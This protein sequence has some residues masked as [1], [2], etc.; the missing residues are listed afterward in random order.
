MLEAD[1]FFIFGVFYSAFVC[2]SAIGV[3]WWLET[4]D[5]WGL[6]WLGDVFII[7]WIGVS[8]TA[9]AWMKV[10]MVRVPHIHLFSVTLDKRLGQPTIQYRMQYDGHHH[11][12]CPRQGGWLGDFD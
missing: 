12:R 6:E 11:L 10:R 2:L 4:Q 1:M 5:S 3:F 9:L 8:I 7:T